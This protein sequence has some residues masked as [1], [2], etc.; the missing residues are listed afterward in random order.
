MYW[1]EESIKVIDPKFHFIN[2]D[3][4]WQSVRD[5]ERFICFLKTIG[6]RA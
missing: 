2:V 5:D 3:P 1:A 6:F 4:E